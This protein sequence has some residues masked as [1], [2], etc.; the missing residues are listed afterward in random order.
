MRKF[1]FF[2]AS[3]LIFTLL[4][5]G[6]S[7]QGQ[8]GNNDSKDKGVIEFSH[9]FPEF[10]IKDDN[11]QNADPAILYAYSN[12]LWAQDKKEEA[13]FWYYTAQFRNRYLREVSKID[14]PIND[15]LFGRFFQESG[16]M[17][18]VMIASTNYYLASKNPEYRKMNSIY[19]S[20]TRK[21]LHKA[22][23]GLGEVINPYAF[24]NL[25][26][27]IQ[28]ID[29]VIAY[30]KLHPILVENL[31][32]PDNLVS[33]EEMQKG[34]EKEFAGLEEFKSYLQNNKEKIRE[35]RKKA[36]LSNE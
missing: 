29:E 34:K 8:A 11:V 9:K 26:R 33:K 24:Q 17:G 3:L 1:L 4:S 7:S 28:R 23:S 19:D 22:A 13:V 36:G 21:N 16:F 5:A 31:V 32:S 2:T 30:E 20:A 25:D 18:N 6:C 15:A 27:H 14:V 10:K 12:Y 35:Q